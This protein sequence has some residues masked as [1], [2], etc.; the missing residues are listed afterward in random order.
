MTESRA[1]LFAKLAAVTANIRNIPKN[2]YNSH[3]GYNF[4]TDADVSSALSKE[5]S[6]RNIQTFVSA[7]ILNVLDYTKDNGKKT[8]ITDVLA[9]VT[10]ACGDT[11]ETF[12][13]TMPGTGD[14]A[15]DKGTYKAITGAVKY[16]LL[17]TFLVATGDDPEHVAE[18]KRE[19][20]AAIDAAFSGK[21]TPAPATATLK[22]QWPDGTPDTPTNTV[23]ALQAAFDATP[24]AT[25]TTTQDDDYT[26]P[27]GKWKGT[28][29][30]DVEASYLDWLLKQP[31]KE[32][33]E[34]KH[35]EQHAMFRRELH[36]REKATA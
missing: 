13:V 4:A 26:F 31:A 25:A 19:Q 17:K 9:T 35:A 1:Q 3:F 18:Q 30:R 10:F 14:D 16:A 6:E 5:L 29:L 33:M 20:A 32:G 2:G 27:F 22:A 36:R 15:V 12:T 24:A 21:T 34:Q 11:G 7:E 23:G 8:R 28:H